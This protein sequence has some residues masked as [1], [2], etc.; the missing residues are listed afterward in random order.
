MWLAGFLVLVLAVGTAAGYSRFRQT[1]QVPLTGTGVNSMASISIQEIHLLLARLDKE[2][3]PDAV[4]GAMCYAPMAIPDSAEYICPACG[5]KTIYTGYQTAGF[6]WNLDTARRLAESIDSAADLS[7]TLDEIMFCEF[8]SE[9]GAASPTM[10]LRVKNE[11]GEETANSVS[12]D[13]LR[14][15]DSFL[16]GRLFWITSNDGQQPLKDHAERMAQL[17]GI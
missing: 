13:D 11:L 8:C 3:E 1:K 2:D 5:E 4:Q 16:Q 10:I 9:Q 6:Q 12:V 15:L 14:M 17:L 7:V